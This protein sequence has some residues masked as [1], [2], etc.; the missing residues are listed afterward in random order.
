MFNLSQSNQQMQGSFQAT[1]PQIQQQLCNVQQTLCH[2]VNAANNVPPA[3]NVANFQ[4]PAQQQQQGGSNNNSWRS[5]NNNNNNGRGFDGNFGNNN[6]SFGGTVVATS[7]L[8][9]TI[10][11]VAALGETITVTTTK[12]DQEIRKLE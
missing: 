11:M 8:V 2:L 4:Q 1:L 5:N 9:A 7:Y 10:D 3:F 6:N 12:S